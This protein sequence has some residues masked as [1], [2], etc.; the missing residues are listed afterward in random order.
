MAQD[1]FPQHWLHNTLLDDG[2]IAQKTADLL[3]KPIAYDLAAWLHTHFEA[4]TLAATS[5][6]GPR[7]RSKP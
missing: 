5:E 1:L 6:A 3:A 4:S 2:F 7:S